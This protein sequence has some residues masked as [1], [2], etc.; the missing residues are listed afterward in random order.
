M[1]LPKTQLSAEQKSANWALF[2]DC[3]NGISIN[4][5]FSLKCAGYFF[6]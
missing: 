5:L 1:E 2:A 4:L 6:F 3:M